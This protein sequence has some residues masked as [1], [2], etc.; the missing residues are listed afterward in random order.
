MGI[1]YKVDLSEESENSKT[2][3]ENE[4]LCFCFIHELLLL[5]DWFLSKASS[6]M[7]T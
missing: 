6:T 2:I 4:R 1:I 7:Q 5:L 3:G